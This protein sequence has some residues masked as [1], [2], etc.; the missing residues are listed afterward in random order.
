MPEVRKGFVPNV[1]TVVYCVPEILEV[2]SI[3]WPMRSRSKKHNHGKSHGY[4]RVLSGEVYVEEGNVITVYKEGDSFTENPDT[5]H[6]V[7]SVR[8]AKT[9]HFYS[10][11]ITGTMTFL[12]DG[13]EGDGFDYE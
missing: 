4:T 11:P 12:S 3:E 10:P 7:G 2:V 9:L 13:E 5:V 1:R 6:V 8:G